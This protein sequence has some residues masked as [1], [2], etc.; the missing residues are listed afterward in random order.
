[1]SILETIGII[2]AVLT[3]LGALVAGCGYAWGQ[4]KQGKNQA[5]LD[6]GNSELNTNELLKDQIDALKDKVNGQDDL[7]KILT[8]KVEALT[9]E[10]QV[11]DKKF[12]EAIL[13]IQGKDPQMTE[14]IT[15][16]KTFIEMNRPLLDKINHEVIPTV[17][18][19][20]KYLN[21]QT[22]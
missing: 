9:T 13:A 11:R 19:L 1:M 21:T 22:F 8:T 15:T 4:F 6:K 14:F 12:T 20:Q 18:N 7:I 2:I 5:A 3:G 10:I 17:E 16:I